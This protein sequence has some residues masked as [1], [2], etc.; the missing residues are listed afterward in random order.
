[1]K[2]LL[3][4]IAALGFSGAVFS[5]SQ[6][7]RCDPNATGSA[8]YPNV[9]CDSSGKLQVT[10][11]V[12]STPSGNQIVVGPTA[13][14]A[15]PSTNP[16]LISGYDG[17]LTRTIMTD[18]GGNL[19]IGNNVL[20]NGAGDAV[21]NPIGK[22]AGWDGAN[23]RTIRTDVLGA[24]QIAGGVSS[25]YNISAATVV[26]ATKGTLMRVSVITAGTT[27]GTVNDVA[28]TGGAAVGNQIGTIPDTVG[29]YEFA[30]PCATG[31]VVV[32]GTGQVLAVSYN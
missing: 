26:K 11:T 24:V 17:T 19:R 27:A 12:S 16:V 31:I 18:T 21:G 5:Q 2:R 10:G 1:M 23:M 15:A 8:Q 20:V 3:I 13:N 32:P 30:W 25:T 6:I 4:A 14:G 28:T 9:A 7:M 22:V 29:T